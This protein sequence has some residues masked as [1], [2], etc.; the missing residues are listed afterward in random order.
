MTGKTSV[1]TFIVGDRLPWPDDAPSSAHSGPLDVGAIYDSS[2]RQEC[3]VRRISAL[4]AT[5]CA[6][7]VKKPGDPV[8]VELGNG[9]R[10]AARVVW[11][12]RG[13]AGVA[14]N[15]PIDL[16]ALINRS[17]VNQPAERRSMPRV[18]IRCPVFL[19]WAGR[20]DAVT[21]RNISAKG[22]QLQGEE[23][24]A[25]GT[26][27]SVFVDGLVVPAGEVVW[28]KDDLAGVELFEEMSWTSL[29]PWIRSMMRKGAP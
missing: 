16:L 25:R 20:C 10:P 8:A 19:R 22:L 27:L 4:G 2:S 6:D 26:F 14:F 24:P 3:F 13:E 21:L 1:T 29:V 17:L 5:L 12:R 28:R 11:V 23:L 18:E 15:Q 9:Q 7:I